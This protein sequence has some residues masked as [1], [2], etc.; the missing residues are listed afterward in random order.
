MSKRS[1]LEKIEAL[2]FALAKWDRELAAESGDAKMATCSNVA[3]GLL[4]SQCECEG[5][6]MSFLESVRDILD[7]TPMP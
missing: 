5:C 3:M 4:K 7:D 1:D 2:R 6:K